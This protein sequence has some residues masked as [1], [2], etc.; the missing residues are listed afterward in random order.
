MNVDQATPL[1]DI[2]SAGTF[3]CGSNTPASIIEMKGITSLKCF[4]HRLNTLLEHINEKCGEYNLMFS[5][6]YNVLERI[7]TSTVN[8]NVS[9]LYKFVPDLI[10]I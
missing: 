3:D 7:R 8:T 1:N 4:D 5:P 6:I 2:I 10:I 9:L